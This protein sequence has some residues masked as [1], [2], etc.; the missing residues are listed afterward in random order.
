M[1][2]KITSLFQN[3]AETVAGEK[4]IFFAY[5]SS[6]HHVPLNNLNFSMNREIFPFIYERVA[7]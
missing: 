2:I 3:K 4:S 7:H 6:F 5:V 1:Q